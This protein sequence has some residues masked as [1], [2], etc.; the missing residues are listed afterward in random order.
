MAC[1][2]FAA[3]TASAFAAPGA[4]G[5]ELEARVKAEFVER[6]TH[7]IEWPPTAFAA[8]DAPFVLCV[9]GRTPVAAN[10]EALARARKIKDRRVELRRPPPNGDLSA[11][12]VVF[13]A[14]EER[15]RLKQILD[16]VAGHPIVTI[17]DSEGFARAG[18][19]INLVLDPEGRVRFEISPAGARHSA[20][21]LNAQLLRLSRVVSDGGGP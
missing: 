19:L 18:V 12:H 5:D 1:L 6:F 4:D 20:L 2:T 13:I 9:I 16:A 21:T 11:C 17:A 3:T 10:L 8:P 15:P 7:F 14:S